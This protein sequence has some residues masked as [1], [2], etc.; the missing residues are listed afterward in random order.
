[1]RQDARH[2]L[3]HRGGMDNDDALTRRY[4]ALIERIDR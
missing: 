2:A 4:L 3:R 1:M